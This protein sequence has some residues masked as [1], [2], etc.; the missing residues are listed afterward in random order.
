MS[1]ETIFEVL[2]GIAG[3]GILI[4][5]AMAPAKMGKPYLEG[6]EVFGSERE[7]GDGGR[8]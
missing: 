6:T 1:L 3:F 2:G 4:Y 7:D 5:I 8:S